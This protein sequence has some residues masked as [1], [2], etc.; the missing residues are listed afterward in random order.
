MKCTEI[1]PLLL[2]ERDGALSDGQRAALTRHIAIC[3][4]CGQTQRELAQVLDSWKADV[5]QVKVPDTDKAWA[6]LRPRLRGEKSAPRPKLAR[7]IWLSA[8][9]AAAA[10]IAFTFF[11]GT[12]PNAISPANPAVARAELL[13]TGNANASTMVYVDKESGWLVVWAVDASSNA[14][15]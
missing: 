12:Q 14:N 8:P 10:T 3:P 1:E 5:A 11:S 2:A 4:A 7:M 9:L 15:G 13:D 6:S